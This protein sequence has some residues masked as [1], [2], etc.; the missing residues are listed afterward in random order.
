[1]LKTFDKDGMTYINHGLIKDDDGKRA[2]RWEMTQ[3]GYYYSGPEKRV[4]TPVRVTRAQVVEAALEAPLCACARQ[5]TMCVMEGLDDDFRYNGTFIRDAKDAIRTY[6]YLAGE[7][8][9]DLNELHDEDL[10]QAVPM[11]AEYI[12][13]LEKKLARKAA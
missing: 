3:T 12:T 4:Q 10:A 11:V 2:L 7:P 6:C 1:M 9:E 5:I 8:V 13:S